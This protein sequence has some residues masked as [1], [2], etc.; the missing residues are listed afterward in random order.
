MKLQRELRASDRIAKLMR[1]PRRNLTKKPVALGAGDG[2]LHRREL[3][4]H[5]IDAPAQ[6]AQLVIAPRQRHL[7]EVPGR[8]LP[9]AAFELAYAP[10]DA[11]GTDNREHQGRDTRADAENQT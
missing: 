9:R 7:I 10:H 5:L 2:I 4:G 3:R 11:G 8:D 1:K 6:I